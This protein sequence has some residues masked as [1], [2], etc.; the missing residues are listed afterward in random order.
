LQLISVKETRNNIFSRF[1]VKLCGK[2]V[3][4][5]NEKVLIPSITKQNRSPKNFWNTEDFHRKGINGE[6]VTI[7]FL[8]SGIC[9]AHK[10]FRGRIKAVH[11]LTGSGSMDL[12][13]DIQGHGTMCVSIACG[14]KFTCKCTGVSIQAGVA[15]KANIAM[16]KITNEEDRAH[17]D[18]I[19]K[20]LKRCLEDKEK[21]GIDIVLLSYG[22]EAYDLDVEHAIQELNIAQ[23]LV[24]TACGN[25]R[26]LEKIPFPS[27]LFAQFV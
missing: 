13:V 4:F 19:T 8:D 3:C 27:R 17:P 11:D 1:C 2:Q 23:V 21:Y 20:A 6:G 9:S 22:S 12:R 5:G 15:P 10:A 16:Y 24:V 18:I 14:E 26:V 7:A 25:G